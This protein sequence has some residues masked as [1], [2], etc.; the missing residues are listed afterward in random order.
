M[1]KK[2]NMVLG[3][4]VGRTMEVGAM[5]TTIDTRQTVKDG[6]RVWLDQYKR[7]AVKAATFTRLET[8]YKLMLHYQIAYV[9]LLDLTTADVQKYI[10]KLYF[11]RKK[12]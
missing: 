7:N 12:V 5:T 10:N 2:Q 3:M 4:V 6:V 11:E 9:R 8:E 1:T